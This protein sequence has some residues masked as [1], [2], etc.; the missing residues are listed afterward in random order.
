MVNSVPSFG[1]KSSVGA[2]GPKWGADTYISHA[3]LVLWFARLVAAPHFGPPA[4]TEDFRSMLRS[5]LLMPGHSRTFTDAFP[6]GL[7]ERPIHERTNGTRKQACM[8]PRTTRTKEKVSNYLS[9][10]VLVSRV[11]P[12]PG[13]GPFLIESNAQSSFGGK[14]TSELHTTHSL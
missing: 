12:D 4:P 10:L 5:I 7:S 11:S 9:G 14:L 1:R 6:T 3:L 8:H 13:K 2:G